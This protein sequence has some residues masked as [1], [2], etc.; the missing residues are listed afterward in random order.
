MKDGTE[1]VVQL[2]GLNKT[3]GPVRAVNGID[4]EIRRGETVALLGPNGA[5]KTTTIS[6]LLGLLTPTSGTV[7]V[8][9]M[10]PAQAIQQSKIGAMLQEGRL[11]PGVRVGEFID[12]VRSLPPA[13]LS[14]EKL[15]ELASLG[16]L[17][18]RRVDRLS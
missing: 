18:N 10:S 7:E 17:E 2:Q 1:R 16:P 12:F 13:P 4:L 6:M 3:F 8:F 14:R 15:L 5:G 11:M 9:G